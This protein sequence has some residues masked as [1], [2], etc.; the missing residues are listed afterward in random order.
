MRAAGKKNTGSSNSLYPAHLARMVD[1]KLNKYIESYRGIPKEL[2]EPFKYCVLDGGKRFRPVLCMAS[3]VS[4][5]C[6]PESVLPTACAIEFIHCYSLIHDD[7]PAIDNDDLRRGKPSCHKKF[8]EAMAILA[9]DALFAESFNLILK[10]Q[11]GDPDK[12]HSVLSE[13]IDASGAFGMVAGQVV[14][15]VTTSKK[16]SKDK[17][18]YMHLNKTARLISASVTSSAILCGAEQ[19]LLERFREYGLNIGLAFQITDD[20][21]DIVSNSSET[22]KTQGK[23]RNLSKNTYPSLWG[24]EKSR[25]IAKQ[26]IDA[27][28]DALNKT[29]TDSEILKNI[30]KFILVRRA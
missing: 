13:I 9:G 5:G 22:G 8:G 26:K 12:I 25:R 24:I 21:I 7:L 28:L 27:A 29:K 30:A 3:A 23:D 17:L 14:D 2:L 1:K 16:I 18:D 19:G 15:V 4:L 20:I 10:Y 6:D 11:E